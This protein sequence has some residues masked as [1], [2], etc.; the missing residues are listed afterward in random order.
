MITTDKP[1][2]SNEWALLYADHEDTSRFWYVPKRI[3]FANR[4][5]R[6]VFAFTKYRRADS[7][8]GGFLSFEVNMEVPEEALTDLRRRAGIAAEI[9]LIPVPFDTGTVQT[10]V[11]DAQSGKAAAGAKE[12]LVP[13]II[14]AAKPSLLGANTAIFS[15]ELT[16]DGASLA[17]QAL[18]GG[19]ALIGV[20]YDL[21]YKAMRP[22]LRVVIE[23]NKEQIYHGLSADLKGQYATFKAAVGTSVERLINNGTL[24]ITSIDP[25]GSPQSKESM[26]EAREYLKETLL[27]GF[28]KPILVAGKPKVE[29]VAEELDKIIARKKALDDLKPKDDA[30]KKKLDAEKKDLEAEIARLKE[31]KKAAEAG[32]SGGS[33]AGEAAGAVAALAG[34]VNEGVAAGSGMPTIGFE[35]K[36]VTQVETGSVVGRFD[37]QRAADVE[38]APQAFIGFGRSQTDELVKEGYFRDATLDDDFWKNF[39]VT[40]YGPSAAD[41]D[42]FGIKSVAVDVRYAPGSGMRA[43]QS[44]GKGDQSKKEVAWPYIAGAD[45]FDA[46]VSY[47]FDGSWDAVPANERT[48]TVT[49]RVSHGR[50]VH[51]APQQDLTFLK[52]MPEFV[53]P[54]DWD[55]FQRVEVQLTYGDDATKLLNLTKNAPGGEWKLRVHRPNAPQQVQ[56]RAAYFRRGSATADFVVP[57]AAAS[58]GVLPLTTPFSQRTVYVK[59]GNVPRDGFDLITVEVAYD[60]PPAA[61]V[62][63]ELVFA[64]GETQKEWRILARDGGPSEFSWR[65]SYWRGG[66][67]LERTGKQP[68]RSGTSVFM[69]PPPPNV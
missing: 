41:F 50:E 67:P 62:R 4:D 3:S 43:P 28:F 15:A 17:E 61:A 64:A 22:P 66:E 48:H 63:E 52:V 21:K 37:E 20:L 6:S 32:D 69:V 42:A 26:K 12:K 51:V 40:V 34:A 16:Q 29:A 60:D 9:P 30:E 27:A 65:V 5:G 23:G 10:F 1:K 46:H 54:I 36:H 14:G 13:Q 11:L 49:H 25:E 55:V 2:A 47:T 38:Y 68:L 33:A 24:N 59:L 8:G 56:Y 45:S 31:R 57:A 7:T 39:A 58:A 19:Q 44:F 53:R 18:K 35:L